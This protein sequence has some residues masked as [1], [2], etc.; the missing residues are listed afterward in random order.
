MEYNYIYRRNYSPEDS[1]QN[2]DPDPQPCIN[3]C[4]AAALKCVESGRARPGDNLQTSVLHYTLYII[5]LHFHTIMLQSH[6]F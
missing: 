1:I 2:P 6:N 3:I 5:L 4:G